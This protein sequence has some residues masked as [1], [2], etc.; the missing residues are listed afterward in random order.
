MAGVAA[1]ATK[2]EDVPV[3]LNE[4]LLLDTFGSGSSILDA[5]KR[6]YVQ[7]WLVVISRS[8]ARL[9]PRPPCSA[10]RPLRVL[11][12]PTTSPTDPVRTRP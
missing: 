7:Q 6:H 4:L 3:V 1:A 12:S 10:P 2:V 5:I 8:P 11:P 9:P